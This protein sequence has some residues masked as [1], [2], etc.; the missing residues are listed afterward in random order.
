MRRIILPVLVLLAM[1]TNGLG[2]ST[3]LPNTVQSTERNYRQNYLKG[4]P[5]LPG[6]WEVH[7]SLPQK[8]GSLLMN[9]RINIHDTENLRGV[10]PA[11]HKEIT[12]A[13]SKW[14][15]DLGRKPIVKEIGEFRNQLDK[16]YS[17]KFYTPN[18][19]YADFRTPLNH[20]LPQVRTNEQRLNLY[21]DT[22]DQRRYSGRPKLMKTLG[23]FAPESFNLPTTAPGLSTTVRLRTSD[24]RENAQTLRYAKSLQ[25]DGR[26]NVIGLNRQHLNAAGK[27][28]ADI[29]FRHKSTG[30]QVRMEVKHMTPNSQRANLP[31]IK[32]QILKM[33]L[34][35]RITGEMQVWAN[36]HAIQPEVRVFAKQH[37]IRVEERLRAGG[38]TNVQQPGNRSFQDFVKDMDNELRIQARLS[39]LAGSV[40]AGMGAYLAYQAIGQLE[41]DLANFGGT[42][43]DWLRVGEHGST[44]LAGAGSSVAGAAQLVRQIPVLANSARLV[45]LT[46]WGGRLGMAGSVLAEVFLVN[47]YIS[48]NLTERQFWHGQASLGGGLAGGG[49]GGLVGFKAGVGIGGAIGSFFGPGGTIIGAGIGGTIGLIGGGFGGGYAGAHFAGLGV[50]GRYRL[51]DAEQQEKYSQF[52]L[53]HYQAP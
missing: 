48:G 41:S 44:L 43:G 4:N 13:W 21:R 51:K 28:D 52:L 7:H 11:T 1:A 38:N 24:N 3:S 36:S 18:S 30:L 10:D 20:L 15:R 53:C 31:K 14:E 5:Y 35:A 9:S 2:Q 33:A 45:R 37:G 29:V 17:G 39:A 34:D 22:V 27:T 50:E 23:N 12:N 25:G 19:K 16:K 40:K 47:Q 6:G 32:T 42:H 46:K 49:A 8:Y 26:F